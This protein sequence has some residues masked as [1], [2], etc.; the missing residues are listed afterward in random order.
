MQEENIPNGVFAVVLKKLM[1]ERGLTQAALAAEIGMRQGSI[2]RYL[3]G[4]I[5]KTS[6]LLR[7]ADFFKVPSDY[8]LIG[9]AKLLVPK[10]PESPKYLKI[11]KEKGASFDAKD[12]KEEA[13]KTFPQRL[14]WIRESL[15]LSVQQFAKKCGYTPGYI[16]RLERGEREN[17]SWKFVEALLVNF[18]VDRGWIELGVGSPFIPEMKSVAQSTAAH[19]KD[20]NKRYNRDQSLYVFR[21]V[22]E[23]FKTSVIIELMQVFW[24]ESVQGEDPDLY[25][26][27][28]AELNRIQTERLS[29]A[30][31]FNENAGIDL[32]NFVAVMNIAEKMFKDMKPEEL[33]G[34]SPGLASPEQ[35]RRYFDLK[36]EGDI[37]PVMAADLEAAVKAGIPVDS[38]RISVVMDEQGRLISPPA[39][40][41]LGWEQKYV[42]GELEKYWKQL[43][44]GSGPAPDIEPLHLNPDGSV[45]MEAIKEYVEKQ[46]GF[47]V[48]NTE[49]APL[50][51]GL[52]SSPD[53]ETGE[54]A[55]AK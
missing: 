22:A 49:F 5:P 31:K 48:L 14:R 42:L 52:Q 1:D 23:Q 40:K 4:R 27:A 25:R 50:N 55:P 37:Y 53:A 51:A 16:S 39:R 17:Y 34:S 6:E 35:A 32:D 33:R 45:S 13:R 28:L 19:L 3:R 7:L 38:L 15:G 43:D 41:E 47:V 36:R 9:D 44:S 26:E 11:S 10:A 29:G 2:S 30:V 54:K 46:G 20:L 8:L 12:V 24:K 21:A 18:A